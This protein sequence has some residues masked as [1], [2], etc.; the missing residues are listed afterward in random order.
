MQG[1]R[2]W[3]GNCRKTYCQAPDQWP[4]ARSKNDMC[5]LA[6]MR[7]IE[8][9][10]VFYV[11]AAVG[12]LMLG[13]HIEADE[14]LDKV[15]P[16]LR[17]HPDVLEVRWQICAAGE[18][19]KACA[20]IANAII[21]LDPNRLFG[22]LGRACALRR[23]ARNGL[24]AAFAAL[25]PAAR[26]FPSEPAVP[27]NLSCYACQ[28]GRLEDASAWLRRTFAVA[29]KAGRKKRFRLMALDEPDLEPLWRRI[30]ELSK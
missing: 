16:G 8:P 24:E 18:K 25:Y 12:W 21:R 11:S 6:V 3:Y 17:G 5:F 29:D 7:P 13:D 19:W 15:T 2:G 28:L 26:K 27:F 1:E 14:E 30:G 22:W 23:T 9:P 10:D 20:E 4:G